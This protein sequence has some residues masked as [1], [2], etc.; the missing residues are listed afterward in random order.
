MKTESLHRTLCAAEYGSQTLAPP[1]QPLRQPCSFV[2][3]VGSSASLVRRFSRAVEL[4]GHKTP[5][6]TLC[7]N[8]D[9]TLLLSGSDDCR[10][11]IWDARSH[12]LRRAVETG[13]TAS[14]LGAKFLETT[15]SF[16][17]A[18]CGA[19]K[20]VRVIDFSRNAVRPY[21]CHSG[22]VKCL[23][24]LSPNVFL[25]GADDGVVCQY[26]TRERSTC[27]SYFDH[28]R[29]SC[30]NLLVEQRDEKIDSPRTSI[31]V[32][33]LAV[34]PLRPHI[35]ATGG[36]S[37][38][39]RL[40]DRRMLGP[41]AEMPQGA[42]SRPRWVCCYLGPRCAAGR[43]RQAS[44]RHVATSLA[45]SFNGR[46]LFASFSGD[47]IYSF[48]TEE[49]ALE[50]MADPSVRGSKLQLR[51]RRLAS[52]G[53]QEAP[54]SVEPVMLDAGEPFL[55]NSPFDV[56]DDLLPQGAF[57]GRE[58]AGAVRGGA[59]SG[60]GGAAASGTGHRH[61]QGRLMLF[62]GRRQDAAQRPP[63]GSPAGALPGGASNGDLPAGSA[64]EGVGQASSANG[65]RRSGTEPP[66]KRQRTRTPEGAPGGAALS[67]MMPTPPPW[68]VGGG[69]GSQRRSPRGRSGD[70]A[71]AAPRP[72]GP[73]LMTRL[74][75]SLFS[76][77]AGTSPGTAGAG[78][79]D[80]AAGRGPGP[81]HG[82]AAPWIPLH[83][84][85]IGLS[86]GSGASPAP[87]Q[88]GGLFNSIGS[89]RRRR[90]VRSSRRA[91]VVLED[92]GMELGSDTLQLCEGSSGALFLQSYAGHRHISSVKEISLLG[93]RSE[94]VVSGSEDGNIFIWDAE[95][96]GIVC[97]LEGGGTSIN[98]VAAHPY[99]PLLSSGSAEGAV[100]L[101]APVAAEPS[102]NDNLE[103]IMRRNSQEMAEGEAR[104]EAPPALVSMLQAMGDMDGSQRLQ[105]GG[106]AERCTMQ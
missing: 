15:N 45:F 92:A 52:H 33:S 1:W 59:V 54:A 86:L 51:S 87:L 88:E 38:F 55:P 93:A 73:S 29:A 63:T 42:G 80:G 61:R 69:G 74:Q 96:G 31:G 106:A 103:Y 91:G 35:F 39:V 100:Q 89:W 84:R 5:V 68:P 40:Y 24:A 16:N 85:T 64:G 34:D 26:D 44:I 57:P 72:S 98:S 105:A 14:I 77:Q 81:Q 71:P 76:N 19:D 95:T 36:P 7:W 49:H 46:R 101:W 37:S 62:W 12:K 102:G 67:G 50:C 82:P 78:G 83:A 53:F 4:E 27:G 23:A 58:S 41:G 18:T 94:Y 25:S 17:I 43:P 22:R 47:R 6:N 8:S 9:G 28:S 75:Q 11:K 13:H 97:V 10:V 90:R 65:A 56:Q 48:D 21:H 99:D 3:G 20:Q 60:E 30:R 70:G 79:G 104:R 2:R 32:S 66:R